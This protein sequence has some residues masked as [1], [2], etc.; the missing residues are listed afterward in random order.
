M[1]RI[2]AA[3]ALLLFAS[4]GACSSSKVSGVS[5]KKAKASDKKTDEPP[6]DEGSEDGENTEIAVDDDDLSVPKETDAELDAAA[7][8]GADFDAEE[9]KVPRVER[10]WVA[11]SG[12]Y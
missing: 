2:C 4:S 8:D 7:V 10:C 12:T 1:S 9:M 5:S 3:F 11:V 6:M